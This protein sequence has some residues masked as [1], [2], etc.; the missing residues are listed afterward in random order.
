M[1]SKCTKL[2]TENFDHFDVSS[3]ANKNTDCGKTAA[4]LI[5]IIIK[6]DD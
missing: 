4:D 1:M 2:C 5:N 3:K 6:G